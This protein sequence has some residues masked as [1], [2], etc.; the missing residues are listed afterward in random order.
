MPTAEHM[1]LDG[2]IV[3]YADARIHAFAGVVKYGCGVF[4]GI[5]AYWNDA[6]QELYL[7]RLPEHLERM[8]FGMKLMRFAEVY[9]Q[10]Y[11]ADCVLRLLRANQLRANAHIRVIA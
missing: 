11:L 9:P 3:P 8:R 7:F 10:E 5:R 2:E 1:C 6:A 4:E